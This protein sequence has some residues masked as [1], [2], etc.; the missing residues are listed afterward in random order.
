MLL[1]TSASRIFGVGGPGTLTARQALA[2][3]TGSKVATLTAEGL[4]VRPEFTAEVWALGRREKSIVP[5]G[6]VKRPE[7]H[8]QPESPT[9]GN[10]EP[11]PTLAVATNQLTLFEDR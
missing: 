8:L 4:D 2:V 9:E 7:G 10:Q 1:A 11:N 5:V 3:A 6:V